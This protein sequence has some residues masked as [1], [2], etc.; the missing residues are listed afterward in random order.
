MENNPQRGSAK[1]RPRASIVRV[2]GDELISDDTVALTELV[3][4]AYDADAT[5][6][7]IRFSGHIAEPNRGSLEIVDN[8]TGMSLE[9]VQQGWLEPATNLKKQKE[10]AFTKRGRRV[11]GKKGIGRFAASRLSPTLEMTTKEEGKPFEI[12]I[13]QDW[14]EFENDGYLD[15]VELTWEER[16]PRTIAQHGT[17]LNL[18]ILKAAW[19]REKLQKLRNSLARLSSPFQDLDDFKL[20]IELPT[21]FADLAGTVVASTLLTHPNY[22]V[23]GE[24]RADGSYALSYQHESQRE[25]RID[26]RFEKPR[27]PGCGPFT[28]ELRV[29][30]RDSP[31]IKRLADIY[32]RK[33]SEIRTELD[34]AAGVYIY[35]DKFRVLPY[36]DPGTDWL[37]LDHR[38]IQNPTLR[39]SN[40]QV[41][42]AVMITADR[43][44]DLE[45]QSNR[46]GIITSQA[47]EDIKELVRNVL[48][49]LEERRY[50]AR[51]RESAK[52]ERTNEGIFENFTLK[53][54]RIRFEEKYPKDRET[55][56][57]IDKQEKK[58]EESIQVVQEVLARYR[59]L[60]TLGQLVDLI[61]H[62]GRTPLN[63]I[64]S[65][66]Q[67]GERDSAQ[68]GK[69]NVSAEKLASRFRFIYQQ[70]DVLAQLFRRIEPFSG[71]RR[72]RPKQVALEEI[73]RDCFGIAQ[74]RIDE[75]K[76]TIVLPVGRTM[77]TL[78]PA[79]LQLVF[80][81]LL[82]NSLYWLE[83]DKTNNPRIE[84]RIHRND[85]QELEILF[86][87]NGPGVATEDRE[88]IFDPYF[89]K[90][91]DGVGLGLAIAGETV[92]E[93]D[94]DLELV[95]GPLSGACFRITLRRRV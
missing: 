86:C 75:L 4:N 71:R 68:A 31:S 20:S 72:G 41:V 12:H 87:D 67:L 46:E 14:R 34:D 51:P 88:Y 22:R 18:H 59:R 25:E 42:G 77:V 1:L 43:N 95:N 76:V 11:L 10:G 9:T 45:D 69:G 94:G 27:N 64:S 40:N 89:S 38:R 80:W 49:I 29:W 21:E 33:Q 2:L 78:D 82:D 5:E 58:L 47:F 3:K 48:S 44:P 92:A 65:E 24:I 28:V 93:Y 35:R 53:T 15:E 6:V 19:D 85:K 66:S 54:L 52:K 55:L 7:T 91:P 63:K 70:S 23:S 37:R 84:L 62:D 81:N 56:S 50:K 30:D 16:E 79:E 32:D 74:T 36:G 61:L 17:L 8:G 57:L 26:G 90:K 13:S 73:I 39:V 60:A 83:H